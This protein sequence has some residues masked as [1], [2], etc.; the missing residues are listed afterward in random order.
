MKTNHRS[1]AVVFIVAHPDDVAHAMGGTA[2]L[3]RDKYRIHVFC[4]TK[5]ER[6]LAGK[7]PREAGVIR[8]KEERAVCRKLKA[9]VTFLSQMDGEVYSDRKTCKL[10]AD[11][12]ARLQP[13]AIFTL[14]PINR[15][16]DHIAAYDIT[17]Q[18]IKYSGISPDLDVYMAENEIGGV[19]RQFEPDILVDISDVIEHKRDL[20]RLHTSQNPNA[21]AVEKVIERNAFRARFAQCAYVEAYKMASPVT[22]Y[23]SG[24][25]TGGVL[26]GLRE[27]SITRRSG[28]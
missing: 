14:W 20:I 16:R 27:K 11:G 2:W 18:A 1:D 12:L 4:A 25:I 26:L 23:Q 17:M 3:L 28:R 15:H 22:A 6:G 19:T 9:G 8:E 10:V 13:R 24:H 7:T 21:E 5:G